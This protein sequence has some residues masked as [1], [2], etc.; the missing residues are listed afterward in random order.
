MTGIF[1]GSTPI[2]LQPL[3]KYKWW[4][5]KKHR[6]KGEAVVTVLIQDLV[7]P[8]KFYSACRV[9]DHALAVSQRIR[10]SPSCSRV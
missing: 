8:K 10:P 2:N 7:D 5:I 6:V 3:M 1:A 9:L 4:S